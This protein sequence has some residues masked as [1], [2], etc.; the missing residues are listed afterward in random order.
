MKIKKEVLPKSRVKLTIE[1]SPVAM[2][3]YFAEA[4]QKEAASINIPGFRPG[5]APESILR[6]RIGEEKISAKALEVALPLTYFQ[7]IK[8][9]KLKPIEGAK[10]RV[11]EFGPGKGLIYEAE[12]DVLPEVKLGD[13]RRLEIRNP[14][15][16]IKIE[17]QE[18]EAVFKQLQR[19][20]A[21]LKPKDGEA[22]KGDWLLIDF[23]SSLGDKPLEDGKSENHPLILGEG[24]FVPE[25]EEKLLGM[26][27]GEE[28][29]FSLKFPSHF[30]KKELQGKEITFFVRLKDLREIE[31][32]E[33]KDSWAQK[34]GQKDLKALRESVKKTIKRE[35]ERKER[36]RFENELVEEVVK[37]AEV[38]IP[39]SLIKKE[40]QR[41]IGELAYQL[42][43]KGLKFEKYLE[44]MN[45]KIEDL[46]S[47]LRPQAEKNVKIGLIL[48]E[49]AK[50]ENIKVLESEVEK[51]FEQLKEQGVKVEEK[52]EEGVKEKLKGSLIVKK[53]I[54]RLREFTGS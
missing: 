11:L 19:Q 26:R 18:I 35:K 9:E 24:Q 16:E 39:E 8:K 30:H 50:K 45:K 1:V 29:K 54:K 47:D 17:E 4:F 51:E 38:E 12:F 10:V 40:I 28:K 53:T 46:I 2:G 36:E 37:K 32:P 25:F 15:S 20:T 44:N 41:T 49:I 43:S 7:A 14:E 6:E 48:G 34:L 22:K 27:K 23:R 5:K 33:L 3:A 52:D 42:E 13:Y 31:L 21:N